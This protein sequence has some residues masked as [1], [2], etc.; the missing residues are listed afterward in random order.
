MVHYYKIP[1][2]ANYTLPRNSHWWIE[3]SRVQPRES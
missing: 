1:Y 3:S 2:Y